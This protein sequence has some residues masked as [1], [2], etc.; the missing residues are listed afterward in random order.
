MLAGRLKLES[1]RTWPVPR[2]VPGQGRGQEDLKPGTLKTGKWEREANTAERRG[3]RRGNLPGPKWKRLKPES[4]VVTTKY[5]DLM[6]S[7][8]LGP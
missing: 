6:I 3:A 8:F 4:L 7:A 2:S 5:T 1:E